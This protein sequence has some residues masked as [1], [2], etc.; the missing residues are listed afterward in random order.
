MWI[1]PSKL[2][3]W[4]AGFVINNSSIASGGTRKLR[5]RGKKE[6]KIGKKMKN[7]EENAH[8]GKVLSLCP[9]WQRG[10]ATLLVNNNIHPTGQVLGLFVLICSHVA[11]WTKLWCYKI[12]FC[13]FL[14]RKSYKKWLIISFSNSYICKYS[15]NFDEHNSFI[16]CSTYL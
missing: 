8:I 6:G 16:L 2:W 15:V 10:L 11:R 7:Q 12:E 3:P 5:K 13:I 9:S 4:T 14:L 1:R